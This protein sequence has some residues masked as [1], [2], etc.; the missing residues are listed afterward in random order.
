MDPLISI[1]VPNWNGMEHLPVCFQSLAAADYPRERQEWI[2]SDNGSRDGSLAFIRDH[3]PETRIV[4]N[5]GNIGFARGCNA[6]AA[7][8][9]GDY[10]VFLNNDT[11]VD[12]GWLRGY[13]RALA[14]DPEAVC[15]ASY[16]RSWDDQEPDFDGATCN[17]FAVGRQRPVRGWPDCPAGPQEGDPLL[18]ACGGAMLVDRAVFQAVG[19]FDPDHF[20]YF[21][22]VDLGWRLWVLGHRVVYAPGSVVY[23]K[24]GGTTGA[25]RVAGHRRYVLFETNTLAAIVKNYAQANLDRVLPAALLLEWKRALLSAG[26]AIDP[27]HYRLNGARRDPRI[28]EEGQAPLPPMSVAHLLAM[29]RFGERL[30]ALMAARAG[31]Q[32]ARRR[33]DA[34]ILPLFRRPFQAQFAGP[35]YADAM[36]RIA[37]ALDL[38]PLVAEASPSRH[39]AGRAGRG[40]RPSAGGRPRGRARRRVPGGRGGQ[41]RAGAG[42]GRRPRPGGGRGD[43]GSR[44]AGAGGTAGG[45]RVGLGAGCAAARGAGG[46]GGARRAGAVRGPGRG[47]GLGGGAT[48]HPGAG[49][50]GGRPVKCGPAALLPL[51]PAPRPRL[52]RGI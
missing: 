24:E 49:P 43:P 41:R 19:G 28:E 23:H 17:L 30:P 14:R 16:M 18:F 1:V 11:R 34:E 5:G 42:G 2:L 51:P 13:L 8:A 9:H 20:I 44:A 33:P 22:D 29:H 15:A 46:R 36:R 40:R 32:A 12:P 4:D 50:G 26:D 31:I 52:S 21:E 47:G 3:Y 25:K 27:E 37:A 38:Y 45:R 39:P 48:G 35:V 6:G 7:A 10:V